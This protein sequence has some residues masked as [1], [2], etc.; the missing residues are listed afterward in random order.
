MLFECKS[1]L[2]SRVRS[3]I[4]A[5]IVPIK[6]ADET[7]TVVTTP[8]LHNS[9]IQDEVEPEQIAGTGIPKLQLQPNRPDAA[10][11]MAWTKSQNALSN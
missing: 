4:E 1:S 6:P 8:E 11:F 10:G 5:G 2:V 9:P 7:L 3:P